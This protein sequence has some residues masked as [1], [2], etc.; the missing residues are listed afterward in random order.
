MGREE[1]KHNHISL[2][3]KLL[4]PEDWE[5]LGAW[6]CGKKRE[7]KE[8]IKIL[9]KKKKKEQEN[10]DREIRQQT[11]GKENREKYKKA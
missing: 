8:K 10:Y 9:E 6:R 11:I 5:R 2:L 7:L 4:I 3:N 1:E